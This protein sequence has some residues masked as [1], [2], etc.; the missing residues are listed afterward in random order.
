M[1]LQLP[2]HATRG[3][4]LTYGIQCDGVKD[5]ANFVLFLSSKYKG[6]IQPGT[7]NNTNIIFSLV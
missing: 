3:S 4:S 1:T 7:V 5:A 6:G 2:D